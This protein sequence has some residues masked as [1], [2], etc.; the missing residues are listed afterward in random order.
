MPRK[1]CVGKCNS[2]YDTNFEKISE[3]GFPDNKDDID[4][5]IKRLPNK[6]EYKEPKDLRYIGVCRKHWADKIATF[7]K[8]CQ[9]ETT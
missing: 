5:W 7:T 3:H 4:E 6:I 8:K 9:C 2:T 1:C